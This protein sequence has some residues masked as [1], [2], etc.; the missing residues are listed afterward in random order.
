MNAL[1]PLQALAL[2]AVWSLLDEKRQG[3]LIFLEG[4]LLLRLVTSH[5][6]PVC[7]IVSAS[8]FGFS[9]ACGECDVSM[10]LDPGCSELH[11]RFLCQSAL[12]VSSILREGSCA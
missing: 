3:L 1:Q 9:P 11:P 10:V 6:R 7:P 8:G 5:I 4:P 12:P 2:T